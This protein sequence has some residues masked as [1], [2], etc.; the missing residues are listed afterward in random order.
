M[1]TERTKAEAQAIQTE[2]V[3]NEEQW[4][5]FC[6]MLERPPQYLPRL[7]KL[8]SEPSILEVHRVDQG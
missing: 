3:F 7:Q 8:M 2:I 4:N 5:E 1:D 6:A